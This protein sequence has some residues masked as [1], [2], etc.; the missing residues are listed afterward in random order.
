M[1]DCSVDERGPGRPPKYEKRYARQAYKLC[2]LGYTDAEL[3]DFFEVSEM[4]INNWKNVY[5]EF[6]KALKK[7]KTEADS[8]VAA[9]LYKRANGFK[10]TEVVKERH[11][12]E[13]EDKHEMIVSKTMTKLVPPDTGAAMAWLKNRQPKKWRDNKDVN[14]SLN[15]RL[16]DLINDDE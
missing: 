1:S 6:V 12:N 8:E 7:G 5:P 9:S 14:L 10:F 16:E 13:D 3:A 15:E 11:Y 2:L 4:T